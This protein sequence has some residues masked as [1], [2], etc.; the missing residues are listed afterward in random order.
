MNQR[1]NENHGLT[2]ESYRLEDRYLRASGRVF[3]TGTQALVRI[4]LEQPV[5]TASPGCT[6]VAWFLA[7][8]DHRLAV[9]IKSCGDSERCSPSMIFG[10]NGIERGSG[11]NDAVGS[12]AD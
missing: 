10:S 6:P 3:L 4:L 7:I 8:V 11:G 5:L 2:D 12:A 1:A 9:W